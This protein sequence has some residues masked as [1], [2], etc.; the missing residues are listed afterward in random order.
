MT[1]SAR[2]PMRLL[3]AAFAVT[4]ILTVM[5]ATGTGC[6]EKSCDPAVVEVQP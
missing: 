2:I 4:T 3:F 1:G 6:A 5:H